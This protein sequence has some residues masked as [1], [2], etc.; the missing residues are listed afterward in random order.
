FF[1]LGYQDYT[2]DYTGSNNWIGAPKDMGD[3]DNPMYAQ[4]MPPIEEASNL[5][6]TFNV[7][8]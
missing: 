2:F 5:Y 7:E 1:K 6:L 8:F 4:M 3:L